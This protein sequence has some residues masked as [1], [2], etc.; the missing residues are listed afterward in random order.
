[1]TSQYLPD[2]RVVGL[3]EIAELL[4]V[5][6]RT[7]HAW[8]YRKVLPEPDHAS[9]N[10]LKAWDRST[11]VLWAGATGRLPD[12]LRNE[13]STATAGAPPAPT[14]SRKASVAAGQTPS[15]TDLRR[16]LERYTDRPDVE[17]VKA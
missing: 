15:T 3:Q 13:F 2:Y 8:V 11:I 16:M 14:G 12:E 1:M 10:G 7:P 4:K 17:A 5:S 9:V 6:S